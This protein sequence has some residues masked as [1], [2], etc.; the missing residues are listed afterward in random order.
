MS[1]DV[2][3]TEQMGSEMSKLK[4]WTVIVRI[5]YYD[6]DDGLIGD[7]TLWNHSCIT[8]INRGNSWYNEWDTPFGL[9]DML[10][11]MHCVLADTWRQAS[12]EGM[13]IKYSHC[14]RQWK[15]PS[16]SRNPQS[17]ITSEEHLI[18]LLKI[19]STNYFKIT[20]LF[21]LGEYTVY[22]FKET[23]SVSIYTPEDF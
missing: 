1:S 21:H 9:G 3:T 8:T 12:P 15:E 10:P 19:L 13:S 16:S 2:P 5:W 6:H 17:D 4:L 20:S 18:I 14:P 22:L 23:H 11:S 7:I